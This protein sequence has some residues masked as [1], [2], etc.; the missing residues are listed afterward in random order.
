MI[1]RPHR[2]I[3]PFDSTISPHTKSCPRPIRRGE[4]EPTRLVLVVLWTYLT[5]YPSRSAQGWWCLSDSGSVPP[6]VR[7]LSLF[8]L[9]M[10]PLESLAYR[11]SCLAEALFVSHYDDYYFRARIINKKEYYLLLIIE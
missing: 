6:V 11:S 1:K 8:R 3:P 4:I 5:G 7:S 10:V 2:R 9:A